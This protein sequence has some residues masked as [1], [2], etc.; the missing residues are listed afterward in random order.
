MSYALSRPAIELAVRRRVRSYAN[1]SLRD[2]CRVSELLATPDGTAVT[3]V[4]FEGHCHVSSICF[5]IPSD[6]PQGIVTFSI[7]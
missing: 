4:Q 1:I 5:R 2:R 7:T 3:G 6:S